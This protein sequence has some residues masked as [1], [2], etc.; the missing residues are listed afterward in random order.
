MAM[1]FCCKYLIKLNFRRELFVFYF[2]LLPE[3]LINCVYCS[4]SRSGV[5]VC[6][7]VFEW[8]RV[9]EIGKLV[10]LLHHYV[11][12]FGWLVLLD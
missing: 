10:L 1:H 11:F 6:V 8:M 7:W 5:C 4:C 12:F 9:N 3:R 2:T